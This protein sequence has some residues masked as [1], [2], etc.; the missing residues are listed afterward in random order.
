VKNDHGN[1]KEASALKGLEEPQEILS[2][3]YFVTMI[4]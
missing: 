3:T 2:A 1:K 4:L